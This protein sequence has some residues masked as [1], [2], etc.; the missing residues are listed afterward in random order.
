[1]AN[2][3]EMRLYRSYLL[4]KLLILFCV[5]D[6]MG[7]VSSNY[8]FSMQ[9]SL[10]CTF[11]PSVAAVHQ[12]EHIIVELALFWLQN[13]QFYFTKIVYLQTLGKICTTH[14]GDSFV[15]FFLTRLVHY[16]VLCLCYCSVSTC[17][18]T[19][20]LIFSYTDK[21]LGNSI[22]PVDILFGTITFL[23]FTQR[24]LY[25]R[26][27]MHL[28][29]LIYTGFEIINNNT[30]IKYCILCYSVLVIRINKKIQLRQQLYT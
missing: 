2:C 5:V 29:M 14:I 6:Q 18:Q 22:E 12:G 23:H 30:T 3:L 16:V 13:L 9:K 1:M 7:W 17:Q 20:L 15:C 11:S 26:L 8:H 19:N 27:A 25:K 10:T 24:T 4:S 28:N 21:R